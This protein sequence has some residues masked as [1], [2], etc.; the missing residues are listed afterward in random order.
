M[1]KG[2]RGNNKQREERYGVRREEKINLVKESGRGGRKMNHNVGANG[3]RS[4]IKIDG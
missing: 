1:G 3:K 2:V 4:S